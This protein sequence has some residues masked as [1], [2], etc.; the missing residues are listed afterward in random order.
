MHVDRLIEPRSEGADGR[1]IVFSPLLESV[2]S[3]AKLEV[4]D[5]RFV[6]EGWGTSSG[7]DQVLSNF[8]QVAFLQGRRELYD[9]SQGRTIR[10]EW[11]VSLS[12]QIRQVK[13]SSASAKIDKVAAV[14]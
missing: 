6:H 14:G 8:Q 4:V 2:D 13:P 1:K 3:F 12:R 11:A 5:F 9:V 10:W 7:L